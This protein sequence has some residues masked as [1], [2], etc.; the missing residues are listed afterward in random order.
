[1]NDEGVEKQAVCLNVILPNA[2]SLLR[3]LHSVYL[4]RQA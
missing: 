1:M 3:L 2:K 4:L